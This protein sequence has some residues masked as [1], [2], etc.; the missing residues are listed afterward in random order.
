MG[1]LM[2]G[3]VVIAFPIVVV[4][5]GLFAM[6]VITFR[7]P[8]PAETPAKPVNLRPPPRPKKPEPELT[9][10]EKRRAAR[11]ARRGL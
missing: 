4:L 1:K 6:G 8:P 10:K 7:K 11:R 5:F 9:E 2:V 3:Y